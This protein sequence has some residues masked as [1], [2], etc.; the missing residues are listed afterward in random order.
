[1][2]DAIPAT[3]S[4]PSDLKL[5]VPPQGQVHVIDPEGD[6]AHIPQ[7]QVADAQAQGYTL[8]TPEDV[9]SFAV[10]KQYGGIG[11]QVAAGAEGTAQG[12]LGPLAPIAE[13]AAG[14][15]SEGIRGR[16][17]AN[18]V[19]HGVG[20]AA[21]LGAGLLTGTGEA[22]LM[23][24]VGEAAA[25]ATGLGAEGAGVLS[26]IGSAAVK[27]AVENA[28]FQ[29]G[30]EASKMVLQDPNQ[31]LQTAVVNM[32]LAGLIGGGVGGTLGSI[33][34]LW[35]A[36]AG[37]KLG[38]ILQAV[39]DKTGGIEGVTSDAVENAIKLTGVDVA[40]EI[41]SA[42][43]DDPHLQAMAKTLEQSDTTTSGKAYQ[44]ALGGFKKR[45]GDIMVQSMGK[46][47]ETLANAPALSKYEAGQNIGKTLAGEYQ[48]QLDPIAKEFEA[49]K[50]KYKD[51]PLMPDHEVV[52]GFNPNPKV[53]NLQAELDQVRAQRELVESEQNFNA[54]NRAPGAPERLSTNQEWGALMRKEVA[55]Q[56]Q[57]A[58]L[59]GVPI[60]Q[61]VGGTAGQISERLS[62]LAQ[63]EGWVGAEND[64]EREF[65]RVL[66]KLPEKKTLSDL[67][68]FTTQIGDNTRSTLPFGQQTPLSRAGSLMKQVIQDAQDE[69]AIQHLGQEGP[70]L[71]GRFQAAKDAYR[72]QSALREALNDRLKVGGS[73]SGFA[74]GIKN[75]AV[76]DGESLLNRLSGKNDAHL[77]NFLEHNFPKTAQ[78]LKDYH[79]HNTLK[80]AM[81]KA[82]PGELLNPGALRKAVDSMSP[83]LR[84]FAVPA[85]AQGKMQAIGELLDRMNKVPHNFS[86]TARTLDKLLNYLPGSAVGMATMLAGHNPA[87]AILL[88]GLTK[89]IGR[90][91][92]DA[93]RLAMLKFL[94]S[95][96][97]V[98]AEGFKAA[99]DYLHHIVKG[100]SAI[101][102]A[103]KN[104]F[105]AGTS[106][107]SE[108]S[109]PSEAAR[110]KLNSTLIQMQQDPSK[111]LN[112]GGK[113][114][115]YLPDHGVSANQTAANAVNYLNAQR[116]KTGQSM[117][118]DKDRKPSQA[119]M[120]KYNRALDIA[121]Q[122][123]VTLDRL[124]Q[125]RLTAQEV[126]HLRALYPDLYS[127]L[128]Q[129]VLNNVIEQ[130]T[131]GSDIPYRTRMGLSLF[132][133][134]P[135]D[136]TLT[137]SGILGAQP[138][139][140][141]AQPETAT[142][143]AA[144][145][146]RSTTSLNKVSSIYS[147]PVQT[148]A[149]RRN[150]G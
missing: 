125:G 105:K 116:P 80:T 17:E 22:A 135:L 21:G 9:R 30:D 29:G 112:I 119:E 73:T 53:S 78:A 42:L 49:L 32:G 43:S 128:S 83:E 118:L 117:P 35:K 126:G 36:T 6:L 143:P 104:L 40:P 134:Q 109:M 71:V 19:T 1:M 54:R 60:T 75:M 20:E 66:R 64:V 31:S 50:E 89:V 65:N 38:N 139:P 58:Q 122:P 123:L 18:P 67:S 14:V 27:G 98:E 127:K 108:S 5:P 55:L 96:Q 34:P 3:P 133:G 94:G 26:K 79:L 115:Y 144:N 111:M 81:D 62:D 114:A 93:A 90:D 57:I 99:V 24:G 84:N 85:E 131:K 76:T 92:P 145:P 72:Q 15:S 52:T 44:E 97:P 132:L 23:T 124:K 100:E 45:L 113:A 28:I 101:K 141:M 12:L 25:K 41:R 70:E 102:T 138:K 8:A 149:S 142:Q 68:R 7:E 33:S 103:T 110:S 63:R 120:D 130:K 2:A 69:A 59:P 16:E 46:D 150:Q 4:P 86:N 121:Q 136:S 47:P 148:A 56:D 48:E 74:K 91:A 88:G 82:K 37:S 140:P 13:R 129:Q 147:T 61:R 39:A 87:T 51:A 137:P 106:V 10:Q 146:K 95:N 77:L 107:L 11:S